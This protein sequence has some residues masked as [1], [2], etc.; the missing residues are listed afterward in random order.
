MVA[1][2]TC[3]PCDGWITTEPRSRECARPVRRP[4]SGSY[5]ALH[6]IKSSGRRGRWAISV[7]VTIRAFSSRGQRCLPSE[8][9]GILARNSVQ[10]YE[11]MESHINKRSGMW[12]LSCAY[13]LVARP[14]IKWISCTFPRVPSQSDPTNAASVQHK[15]GSQRHTRLNT[16]HL[17][18]AILRFLNHIMDIL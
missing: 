12:G 7:S 3:T 11:G 6:H 4:P 2:N 9:R 13:A 16:N 15:L 5:V 17:T 10:T 8:L 1:K 14:S 18:G